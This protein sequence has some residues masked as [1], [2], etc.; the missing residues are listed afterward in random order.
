MSDRKRTS[1]LAQ[2]LPRMLPDVIVALVSF[3]LAYA[4]RF[5]LFSRI[6]M[7]STPFGPPLQYLFYGLLFALILGLFLAFLGLYDRAPLFFSPRANALSYFNAATLAT[8]GVLFITFA[9]KLLDPSR[10]VLGLAW[11]FA[12]GFLW[13]KDLVLTP[14]FQKVSGSVYLLGTGE[15]ADAIEARL[16]GNYPNLQTRRFATD[17]AGDEV[18]VQSLHDSP[19]MAVLYLL[20]SESDARGLRKLLALSQKLDFAVKIIPEFPALIPQSVSFEEFG[21]LP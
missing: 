20:R 7:F 17:I 14:V 12:W 19:P 21:G 10:L 1:T 15:F 6:R 2:V 8:A 18:F 3:M 5:V 9:L 4:L 11:L 16:R 13:W